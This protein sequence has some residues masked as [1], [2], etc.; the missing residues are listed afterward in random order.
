MST[1]RDQISN[2]YRKILQISEEEISRL[3]DS[4][5]AEFKRIQQE[6]AIVAVAAAQKEYYAVHKSIEKNIT[7]ELIDRLRDAD[8]ALT[9]AL[10]QLAASKSSLNQ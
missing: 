4:F 5:I 2:F 8:L 9:N 3:A 10:E 7:Q 6:N 1:L